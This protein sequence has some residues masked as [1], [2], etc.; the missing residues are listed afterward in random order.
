MTGDPAVD[1]AIRDDADSAS[2]EELEA[3]A[4]ILGRT[5]RSADYVG[6]AHEFSH[7]PTSGVALEAG[8]SQ[9]RS[10]GVIRRPDGE[11]DWSTLRE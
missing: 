6:C 5:V 8:Y 9:C 10:C 7:A 1:A 4:D 11:I 3:T 2:L